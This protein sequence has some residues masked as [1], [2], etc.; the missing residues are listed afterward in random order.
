MTIPDGRH[1][2]PTLR[3][4][5][6]GGPARSP[7][8]RPS[9]P[10]RA[11]APCRRGPSGPMRSRT[12]RI[13][14]VRGAALLRRAGSCSAPPQ[15]AKDAWGSTSR[16]ASVTTTA[17]IDGG[18]RLLEAPTDRKWMTKTRHV[19]LMAIASLTSIPRRQA[20]PRTPG[21]SGRR[22]EEGVDLPEA[23]AV[24]RDSHGTRRRRGRRS[25]GPKRMRR[26]ALAYQVIAV[27]ARTWASVHAHQPSRKGTSASGSER[28]AAKGG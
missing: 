6:T 28:I 23:D 11:R 19:N 17:V 3:R 2:P 1:R 26:G 22:H 27:V 13:R 20:T 4:R 8:P 24:A 25:Q 9:R 10:G 21:P 15:K 18:R 7:A 12:P 14:L 16:V 5:G